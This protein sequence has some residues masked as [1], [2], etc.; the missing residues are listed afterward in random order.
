MEPPHPPFSTS[1][2]AAVFSNYPSDL[3]PALISLRR[4]IF[5]TARDLPEVGALC[6]TL[7]WGQ[8]SYVPKRPRTGTP[9]RLGCSKTGDK[10]AIFTHCQSSV[11]PEFQQQFPDDFTYDGT[12]AVMFTPQTAENTFKIQTLI[13]AAL[14][15]HLP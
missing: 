4:L 1:A 9:L 10:V 8:P 7:K 2:I 12:R 14:T 11:V 15:Y 5:D 6:E 3:R 13:T